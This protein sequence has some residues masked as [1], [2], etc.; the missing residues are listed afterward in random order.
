M[1]TIS[2]IAN[3]RTFKTITALSILGLAVSFCLMAFGMDLSVLA[4]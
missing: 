1:K 3:D 4:L 2:S